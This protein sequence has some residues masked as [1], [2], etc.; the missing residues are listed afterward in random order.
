MSLFDCLVG[1]G[2]DRLWNRDAERLRSLEVDDQLKLGR[3]LDGQIGG[4]LALENSPNVS[5]GLRARAAAN[6]MA[7]EWIAG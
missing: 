6:Q 2:E 5:A 4:F 1:A 3:L 7:F